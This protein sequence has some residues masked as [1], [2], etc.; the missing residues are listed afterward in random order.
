MGQPQYLCMCNESSCTVVVFPQVGG[1]EV[2]LEAAGGLLRLVR[3]PDRCVFNEGV[4]V[5][6]HIDSGFSSSGALGISGGST[7]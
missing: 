7:C 5:Q 1:G 3:R 2:K 6:D 4:C